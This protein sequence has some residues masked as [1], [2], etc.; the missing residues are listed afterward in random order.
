MYTV[1]EWVEFQDYL[2]YPQLGERAGTDARYILTSDVEAAVNLRSGGR[3]GESRNGIQAVTPDLCQFVALAGTGGGGGG[4]GS[5][6]AI[7]QHPEGPGAVVGGG[8]G[9]DNWKGANSGG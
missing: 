4:G 2:S 8:G 6:L 7:I 1:F 9:D 5:R 3:R